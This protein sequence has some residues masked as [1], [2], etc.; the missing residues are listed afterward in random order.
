MTNSPERSGLNADVTI[1]LVE[2]SVAVKKRETV[3][4]RVRIRTITDETQEHVRTS[5]AGEALDVQRIAVGQLIEIGSMPPTVRT[6]GNVTYVPIIEEV[7]VVEKRLLFKEEMRIVRR[8]TVEVVDI[9][10]TLRK[11]RGV[12]EDL[13]SEGNIVNTQTEIDP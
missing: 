8:E 4:D 3:T 13:D 9:P 10:V 5:L 6:E 1:P 11:Q 7:L 2:E 12:V